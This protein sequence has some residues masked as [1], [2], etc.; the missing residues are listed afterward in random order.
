MTFTEPVRRVDGFTRFGKPTHHYV[1][2]NDNKIPGVTTIIGDGLPKPAL[3]GWGIKSVA[4]FAVNNWDDLADL[5]PT[6]QLKRL[7]G[8]PY[9]DRD[10]AARR[11]T[12][13][14]ALAESL[15]NG[16]TVD[17]PTALAG[18]VEGYARWL[19][20]WQPEPILT[21]TTVYNLTHGYA[22]SFDLLAQIGD[23]VWLLDVKTTR[24]GV[25]GDVAYQL[26]AYVN[27]EKFLDDDGTAHDMLAVDKAGVIHV[28]ATECRLVPVTVDATV[29][30]EFLHIKEV[31]AAAKR[32]RSYVGEAVTA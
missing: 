2:G 28:T 13:V 1:D 12:E 31:A 21:E 14:H 3:V 6:D 4:E 5:P 16:G 20:D 26:A 24:S 22:G 7:K 29:F 10:E 8:A 19:E 11:G 18:H 25:Y 30:A 27:A 15:V 9:A 17:V 32:S 23:D